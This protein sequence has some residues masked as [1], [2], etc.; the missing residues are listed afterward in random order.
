MVNGSESDVDKISLSL[1]KDDY[2][3]K[4]GVWGKKIKFSFYANKFGLNW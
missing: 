2:K 4:E 1:D 3:E